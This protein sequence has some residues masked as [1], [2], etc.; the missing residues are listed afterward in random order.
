MLQLAVQ[1][2][3]ER[4]AVLVLL[5]VV[6][7]VLNLVFGEALRLLFYLLHAEVVVALERQ[8]GGLLT[9]LPGPVGVGDV[10]LALLRTLA[11]FAFGLFFLLLAHVLPGLFG[12]V[13]FGLPV[14]AGVGVAFP[15]LPLFLGPPLQVLL[16]LVLLTL[17]A[18]TPLLVFL[19]EE[20]GLAGRPLALLAAPVGGFD[21]LLY[22]FPQLWMRVLLLVV[23]PGH[24][25][26]S[27][28]R[29]HVPIAAPAKFLR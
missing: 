13:A 14:L 4:L 3:D 2:F 27:F 7:K 12:Q 8:S 9:S 10:L 25:T 1:R 5:L 19:C 21:L 28:D 22:L 29:H 16:G 20:L 24:V 6:E 23:L 26:S 17:V 15:G 18:A 11:L